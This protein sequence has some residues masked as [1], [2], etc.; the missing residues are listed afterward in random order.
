MDRRRPLR[1]ARTARDGRVANRS[2]DPHRALVHR[3]PG[4]HERWMTGVALVT[5]GARGLGVEICR[6]L[7]EAGFEVWCTA[8]SEADAARAAGQLGV[9]GA[10]LDVTDPASVEALADQ[11]DA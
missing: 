4:H 1:P 5:G 9:R 10:Q 3:Q 7:A 2:A 11:L 8:R 6:Q